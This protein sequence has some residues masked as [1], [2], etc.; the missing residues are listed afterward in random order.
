MATVQVLQQR[1]T[2]H[3]VHEHAAR[4][5]SS[6]ALQPLSKYV[7][8][9]SVMHANEQKALKSEV[10]TTLT[11]AVVSGWLLT[12]ANT[13]DSNAVIDTGDEVQEIT[14]S[15]RIQVNKGEQ[16]RLRQSGVQLAP[17]GFHLQGPAKPQ[18]MGVGPL[19]MWPGGLCVSRSI[20]DLDAGPLIVPLPHVRQVLMTR[21]RA[22]RLI[23]A[24]DGLWDLVTF[25]KAAKSVRHKL[26]HQ[27]VSTLVQMVAKDRRM[28]DD[29]S[30][31]IVDVLPPPAAGAQ[32]SNFPASAL[33]PIQFMEPAWPG[34]LLRRVLQRRP[35]MSRET[36]QC[37]AAS[38][39]EDGRPVAPGKVLGRGSL[40]AAEHNI[41]HY[42]SAPVVPVALANSYATASTASSAAPAVPAAPVS[43]STLSAAAE[44]EEEQLY[45]L[46]V[47]SALLGNNSH[48]NNGFGGN[49]S[50]LQQALAAAEALAWAYNPATKSL[51]TFEGWKPAGATD[52]FQQL[53]IIDP[54]AAWL[55]IAYNHARQGYADNSAWARGQSWA[56]LGF[57]MLIGEA[58]GTEFLEPAR[59]ATDAWLQLLDRQWRQR[60]LR[61]NTTG[62]LGDLDHTAGA[63]AAGSSSTVHSKPS[64][65][66][67]D[68]DGFDRFIPLWDFDA[69][70]HAELDGPR[71]T[72]AAAVAALGMLYLAEAETS[73]TCSERYLYAAVSTLK[74]LASDK[75]LA[76]AED[77]SFP[78]LLKHAT[79]G[80]PM[81]NHVDVGLISGDYYFLAAL[82]KCLGMDSCHSYPV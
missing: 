54:A 39:T 17:L 72:S 65:E 64:V 23:M 11:I 51:R 75:Y 78:A 77:A 80:F 81:Q 63:S 61:A 15:H 25:S 68:A 58:G 29:V 1:Q 14:Y 10:C 66:A 18:E 8:I 70:F 3:T 33:Q 47:R 19:R 20:G 49:R 22:L 79:G 13:G 69:P 7:D 48:N 26:P 52:F 2:L 43:L 41:L 9:P 50:H 12:V 16:N 42:G 6:S 56:M 82:N 37:T 40:A 62:V 34:H 27:A 35:H 5:Q 44:A 74:A 31:I 67:A 73:T 71:D 59:K 76:T 55:E 21:R 36:T 4:L 24:S 46:G 53:V 57:S 60:Q 28:A 30:I 32:P 45:R 38:E